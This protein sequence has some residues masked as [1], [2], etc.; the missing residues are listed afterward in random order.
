MLELDEKEKGTTWL[1]AVIA[2]VPALS[3]KRLKEVRTVCGLC[4]TLRVMAILEL[5]LDIP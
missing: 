2:H 1:I 3:V 4:D 5:N